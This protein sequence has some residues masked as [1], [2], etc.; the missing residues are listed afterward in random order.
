MMRF[1][2]IHRVQYDLRGPKRAQNFVVWM[3]VRTL[4][5]FKVFKLLKAGM[6]FGL[7]DGG[8]RLSLKK[9]CQRTACYCKKDC[10][11][12]ARYC[13]TMQTVS[14]PRANMHQ[15]PVA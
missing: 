4:L 3:F 15:H 14:V 8:W 10:Q 13:T 5:F 7:S 6:R 2:R 12:T 1:F 11:R 9:D